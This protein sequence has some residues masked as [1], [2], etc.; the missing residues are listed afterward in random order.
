MMEV[1]RYASMDP[2]D[3]YYWHLS[4]IMSAFRSGPGD[5]VYDRYV[6]LAQ[7]HRKQIQTDARSRSGKLYAFTAGQIIKELNQIG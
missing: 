6:A 7:N 4:N 3:I 2:D 1:D 5:E